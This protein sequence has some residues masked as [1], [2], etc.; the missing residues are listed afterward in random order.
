LAAVHKQ[1]HK[2]EL[3]QRLS[4]IFGAGAAIYLIA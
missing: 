3:P 2:K 4:E 1:P